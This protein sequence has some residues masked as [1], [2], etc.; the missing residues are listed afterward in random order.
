MAEQ[1]AR[2][3]ATADGAKFEDDPARFLRLHW[4]R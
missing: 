2:A 4:R 3:I 1:I